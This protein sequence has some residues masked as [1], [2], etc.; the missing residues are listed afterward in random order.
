MLLVTLKE[1]VDL[2]LLNLLSFSFSIY[3]SV[4]SVALCVPGRLVMWDDIALLC[5]VPF[6]LTH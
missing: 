5:V 2:T 6:F 4:F 3:L 1:G